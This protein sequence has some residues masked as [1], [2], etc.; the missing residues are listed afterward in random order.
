MVQ[1]IIVILLVINGILFIRLL[2]YKRQMRLFTR[3][4]RERKNA[5][6]N[7]MV[8]VEY[9]DQ[10]ILALADVLNEYTVRQKQ[11]L[12]QYEQDRR[13]LKNVIA[14]IS[15]DFRTPLTAARGYLQLVEK[16]G[17]LAQEDQ[18]YL[19][20]VREKIAY[21]KELSDEFFDLSALEAKEEVEL[22]QIHL[23]NFL[24]ECILGQHHWI[25]KSGLQVEFPEQEKDIFVQANEHLLKR[26]M[27]NLFANAKKYAV[28]FLHIRLEL[29]EKQV[30]LIMENDL[31]HPEMMEIDRVFEPFY[32]EKSRHSEGS[33]LGLYVVKCLAGQMDCP[34]SAV[35]EGNV[36]RI[37]L[38]IK[39]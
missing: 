5:D 17:R 24:S 4:T 34:V 11:L 33:G 2:Q 16:N 14:G 29:E 13:Q 35:C 18:E 37:T 19:Q 38:G 6:M 8:T 36:F 28:T 32:R 20:I 23:M 27:N 10:D 21:L 30:M 15:H 7:K 12:L 25:E 3:I 22:E 39:V 1:I 9:F 31:E 26:M